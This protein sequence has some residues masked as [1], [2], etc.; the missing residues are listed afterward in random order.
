MSELSVQA[1]QWKVQVA[2]PESGL[3]SKRSSA[4]TETHT[5][6]TQCVGALFRNDFELYGIDLAPLRRG[7]SLGHFADTTR[8]QNIAHSSKAH[9]S[10]KGWRAREESNP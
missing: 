5:R 7:F 3:V 6:G 10:L 2:G 1:S 4:K 8:T 9:K